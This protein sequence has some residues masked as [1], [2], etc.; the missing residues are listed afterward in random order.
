LLFWPRNSYHE[1][2]AADARLRSSLQRQLRH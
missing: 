2:T 1:L